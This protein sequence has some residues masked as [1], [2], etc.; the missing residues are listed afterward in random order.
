MTSF[1]TGTYPGRF[2]VKPVPLGLLLLQCGES[3]PIMTLLYG[4][5]IPPLRTF[6]TPR[7]KKPFSLGQRAATSN[8]SRKLR[9][10]S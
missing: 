4:G 8:F 6:P 3:K 7:Q 9:M 10:L 5:L 2:Q 1:G